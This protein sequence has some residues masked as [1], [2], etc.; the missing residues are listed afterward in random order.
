MNMPLH[1]QPTRT[2]AHPATIRLLHWVWV[3]A[4][5]CMVFSGW[6]IY[7]AAQR[8]RPFSARVLSA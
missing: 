2:A 7:N 5:G 1:H 3:Y 8:L 6:Q 4:I